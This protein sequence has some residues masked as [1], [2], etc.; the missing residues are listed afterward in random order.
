MKPFAQHLCEAALSKLIIKP[1]NRSVLKILTMS[2]HPALFCINLR[3]DSLCKK[4]KCIYHITLVV[5]DNL[6]K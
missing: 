4:I 6:Y 5:L 2:F 1:K 3:M